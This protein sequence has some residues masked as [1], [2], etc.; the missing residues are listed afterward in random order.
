MLQTIAQHADRVIPSA[1]KPRT[2]WRPLTEP[3][4]LAH[5]ADPPPEKAFNTQP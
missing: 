4:V 5:H 2:L 3:P 1:I